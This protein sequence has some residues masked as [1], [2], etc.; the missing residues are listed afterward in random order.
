M[1]FSNS[2]G[3]SQVPNVIPTSVTDS[4]YWRI[5]V[6]PMNGNSKTDITFFR[7]A[8]STVNS[9]VTTDPFGPATASITIPTVTLL[10]TPG[11][12]DLYWLVP[13]ANVDIYWMKPQSGTTDP[14]DSD[15][16]YAWEGYFLSF[17]YGE[18]GAGSSLTIQCNGAM[19]QLDDFLAYPEYLNHPLPYEIAIQRHFDNTRHPSLRLNQC[20][21]FSSSVPSWYSDPITSPEHIFNSANYVAKTGD[22]ITDNLMTD[23]LTPV[24]LQT[25]DVWSGLLTRSTGNFEKVLS[26]YIQPLL[27]A[28]QTQKGSFSLL[29]SKG[30]VPYFKHRTRL[31][32]PVIASGDLE[33]NEATLVVD[34]LW[35]GV[36]IGVTQD[37]SQ[38]TN[39]IYGSGKSLNGNVFNGA[40]YAANG[41]S[42]WFEPFAASDEV[43]PAKPTNPSFSS[44][45]LRKEVSLTFY[46][47]LDAADAQAVS[48]RHLEMFSDPGITGSLTLDTDPQLLD[49]S[50]F[51]R[52]QVTA[53]R[54]VLVKGLFGN[55]EGILFHITQA[56]I[57]GNSSLRL[58]IDNKFRD[59]LT[60]QEI[61][62]RGRDSLVVSRLMGVG[63]YK[64]A[65]EDLLFPW[66]YDL[67]AGYVP[68]S[69]KKSI[70][71][72]ASNAGISANKFP[73]TNMTT[74]SRFSPRSYSSKSSS[75]N[76]AND[77]Y[78]TIT[79]QANTK[80]SSKNWT[81][82]IPV[83]L[84]AA[85]TIAGVKIAAYKDDGSVYSVPFHASLWMAQVT[86]LAMPL[87]P[88]ATSSTITVSNKVNMKITSTGTSVKTYTIKLVFPKV[89]DVAHIVAKRSIVIKGASK[90]ITNNVAIPVTSV[91]GRT[92][93]LTIV[94]NAL[95]RVK[96]IKNTPSNQTVKVFLYAPQSSSLTYLNG[97]GFTY[98]AGQ[99]YP[100]Y[101][102]AWEKIQDDGTDQND[103]AVLGTGDLIKGWG[104]YYEKAGYY[105]K[106]QGDG[107]S[108]TGMFVTDET[109][110]Y[111][112]KN[113]QVGTVDTSYTPTD[114]ASEGKKFYTDGV[115]A[116]ATAYLMIYCDQEWDAVTQSLVARTNSVH[117]LARL[118]HQHASGGQ[119]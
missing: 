98:S 63:E 94:S 40:Q 71:D 73:W 102:G 115:L 83:L 112:F 41:V 89:A 80:N 28:M 4:G 59:Q 31:S 85:G 39:F 91:S 15:I 78:A 46:D 13:E 90:Y 105:P 111:S 19:K 104:T 72:A 16:L 9:L 43:Y 48:Q 116:R 109:F 88:S 103:S 58:T 27:A 22:S 101:P 51:P 81:A 57:D 54:T 87:I 70:W 8:P 75:S 6:D 99:A 95:G 36:K 45:V 11:F 119:G 47:G 82:C 12:G 93:T 77:Y 23:Y 69:S 76:A 25:G 30:R 113:G 74:D 96:A 62:K 5:V 24:S 53:G 108:P 1:T 42:N 20:L 114:N 61:R 65:V 117:F 97:T 34:L 66:S 92:V 118:Y 33:G 7:N 86:P 37:Y 56:S 29:L 10:D 84:S 79:G 110:T 35:P 17:E 38:K 55:K 26:D 3:L 18:D 49:G 21:P 106:S 32:Q 60:V 50:G 52:Q 67:G 107:L 64:P 14:T 44:N 68:L 2:G 100:F